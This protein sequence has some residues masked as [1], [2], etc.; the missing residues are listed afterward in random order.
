MPKS[1]DVAIH[2]NFHSLLTPN[3]LNK[4]VNIHSVFLRVP[5]TLC[6]SQGVIVLHK[7][8]ILVDVETT[9]TDVTSSTKA[10]DN[11]KLHRCGKGV[12]EYYWRTRSCDPKTVSELGSP[13]FKLNIQ[14]K[15]PIE[16]TQNNSFQYKTSIV[17]DQLKF[18]FTPK[19]SEGERL[20]GEPS[21]C[22]QSHNFF[23]N[24]YQP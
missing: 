12:E 1:L 8:L 22:T 18:L 5:F 9:D 17:P 14:S 3:A 21:H 16:L 10:P 23:K 11:R 6:D 20:E 7:P 19:V 2:D 15:W 24:G 13:S 4:P